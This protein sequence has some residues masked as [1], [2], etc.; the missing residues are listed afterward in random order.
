MIFNRA[1]AECLLRRCAWTWGKQGQTSPSLDIDTP[2]NTHSRLLPLCCTRGR[3]RSHLGSRGRDLR[4][5]LFLT[6]TPH[7]Q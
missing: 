7:A 5:G 4:F 3:E 2:F 6:D 1:I